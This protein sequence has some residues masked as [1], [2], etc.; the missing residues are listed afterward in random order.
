MNICD[1]CHDEIC[2][3]GIGCPVCKLIEE[4]DEEINKRDEE[5]NDLKE[6]LSSYKE[7]K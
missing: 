4:S 2:Y 7:T 5:I 3:D 6:E 1:S